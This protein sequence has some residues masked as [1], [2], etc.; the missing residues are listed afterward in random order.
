M[1]RKFSSLWVW[2]STAI[3][4][5]ALPNLARAEPYAAAF[6]V[7]P[8]RS[9]NFATMD[10]LMARVDMAVGANGDSIALWQ[11]G[12]V[13]ATSFYVQRYDARGRTLIG[14][15][16]S[17]G[18]AVQRVGVGAAGNY[19]LVSEQ[20]D[21]AGIGVFATISNRAGN[22]IVPQ[23]RVNDSVAGD[24]RVADI[25]FNASGT[26]AVLWTIR[27]PNFVQVYLKRF[28]ANGVALGPE[29][30][31]QQISVPTSFVDGA[32]VA[33]DAAGN[34]LATWSI[35]DFVSIDPWDVW[36]RRYGANGAALGPAFRVNTTVPGTQRN[37]VV[38]LSGSGNAVIVWT[39]SVPGAS[40]GAVFGQRYA[41]SGAAL[42]G[43]FRVSP[44]PSS[45]IEGLDVAMDAQSGFVV[46]WLG[47][48]FSG[49]FPQ[50]VA[51]AYGS[52]GVALAPAFAVSAVT[53]AFAST[54]SIGMD[55]AGN[56]MISWLEHHYSNGANNRMLARRY[57]PMGIQLQP[58]SNGQSVS[59][60][61]GASNSFQYFRLTVPSGHTTVD[62]SIFGGV[63]D[64]DLYVR[65]G[66]LPTLSAWDGRP[67]L[68]G[69]NEAVRMLSFPPGDWYIGVYGYNAYSGLGL[70]ARSY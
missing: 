24:Q 34:A 70:Q 17:V 7:N 35:G 41:A 56:F 66:A 58:L 13:G 67:Y 43:E 20:A 51:R 2:L 9:F 19:V 29:T 5:T 6:V 27:D 31:V 49:S 45:S 8:S 12:P 30:L 48:P 33:L 38:A 23:F 50:I 60:L 1:A 21:G 57:Y 69:N 26:F 52:G 37:P 25:A 55:Q 32:S 28:S 14:S 39:G 47:E 65:L 4:S 61:A 18:S 64:A 40:G 59:G 36:A 11:S 53:N 46:T 42:G 16:L 3:L 10:N 63:G 15:E 22:L 54:C 44:D 62:A 68:S